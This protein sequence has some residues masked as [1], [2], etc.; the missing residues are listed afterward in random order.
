MSWEEELSISQTNHR[1]MIDACAQMM[2]QSEP[3]ITLGMGYQQ[4]L[5]AFEGPCKEV[6]VMQAANKLIGFAIIQTCGSFKGYIQT[7]C[8]DDEYRGR[9]FGTK[10]L[11]FCEELI[12][13]VSPNIF[14]CV[15]SF[16][17]GALR[18]YQQFGFTLVGELPNFIKE[19]FSELLL[20]KSVAPILGY[21]GKNNDNNPQ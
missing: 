10:M 3:W 17:T 5:P 11:F 14:I 13:K 12:L 4:C 9:G 18:L 15:S 2:S 16:N 6:Y 20:R 1:Q 21:S 8:I 7:L 19:G